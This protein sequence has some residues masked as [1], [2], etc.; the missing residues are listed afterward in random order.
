VCVCV[1]V[2]V[3]IVLKKIF[4]YKNSTLQTNMTKVDSTG[5]LALIVGGG[6]GK[7]TA[8]SFQKR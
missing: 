4:A 7:W 5:S 2:R 1:S 6:G 8:R 3:C